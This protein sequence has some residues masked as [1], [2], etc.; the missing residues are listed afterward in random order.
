[1]AKEEVAP[2]T[3]NKA[4]LKSTT[5]Q[6]GAIACVCNVCGKQATIPT[7]A[8]YSPAAPA[9]LAVK[10]TAGKV[11]APFV[12]K[13]SLKHSHFGGGTCEGTFKTVKNP[14][15]LKAHKHSRDKA[16]KNKQK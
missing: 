6:K 15:K 10:D 12:G 5:K 13:G 1:M 3:S 4:V 2:K 11:I 8:F 16:I 9:K 14:A 7:A